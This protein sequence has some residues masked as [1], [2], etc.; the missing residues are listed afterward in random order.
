MVHV[1]TQLLK[2]ADKY[3]LGALRHCSQITTDVSFTKIVEFI[4]Q[5]VAQLELSSQTILAGQLA[6]KN[7]PDVSKAVLP[8]PHGN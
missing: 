4:V 3:L 6:H 8:I 2:S 7:A 5:E 1:E